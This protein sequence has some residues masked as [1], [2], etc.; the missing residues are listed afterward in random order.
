[1]NGSSSSSSGGSPSPVL[2]SVAPG[3]RREW[4]VGTLTYNRGQLANVF[5]W[6]LWGDFC[7][8]LMDNGVALQAVNLQLKKLGASNAAI[9]FL[10][11]TVMSIMSAF[12]VTIVSTASD[13]TRSRM[14]RRMPYLLWATPPLAVFL[15]GIGFSAQLA[16]MLKNVWPAGAAGLA[17]VAGHLLPGVGSL[18]GEAALVI[19]MMTVMITLYKLCD[20]FPQSIYYYLWADVVPP[21]LMGSF[22][23]LFRVVAAVGIF[24]FE[25]YLLKYA[26]THPEWVYVGAGVLYLVSFIAMS[27]I[28]KEGEYPPPPPKKVTPKRDWGRTLIWMAALVPPLA[29]SAYE[30]NQPWWIG[31]LIG[32]GIGWIAKSRAVA[33]AFRYMRECFSHSYY[34]KFY[35]MNACFIIA[36][37]SLSQF[38][39]FF[40]TQGMALTTER[41][42]EIVSWR[43]IA[44][45]VP[46]LVLGPI[47]DRFHPIRIGLFASVV[48][49]ATSLGSFFFIRGETSFAVLVIATYASISIYQAGTGA[50]LPRLLPR[51][52]YGQFASANAVVFNLGWAVAA[53]VC[54]AFLDRVTGYDSATGKAAHPENYR[55]LFLWFGG[56]AL[57]GVI[58]SFD[59]YR[60]WKKLGGDENYQAPVVTAAEA[61][62]LEIEIDKAH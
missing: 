34:I 19:G 17:W 31:A 33:P 9:G 32:I 50:L 45:L 5:F 55:Y 13:R 26:D 14:G 8:A 52:Q 58:L 15:M 48:V 59:V 11:G 16:G 61:S 57:A 44:A 40:G 36:I 7:L 42:G 25:R 41:Y 28:V 54:G 20:L 62:G 51:E 37:K 30:L 22:V 3:G 38:L 43:N 56:L 4:R 1:M 10:N 27:L 46:A 21:Q 6:L 60:H 2:D 29:G 49:L 35:A 18:P 23:C 24:I 12:L 47:V 53:M 39:L